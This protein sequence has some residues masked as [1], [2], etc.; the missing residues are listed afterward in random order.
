MNP[1]F[2]AF[3]EVNYFSD[4]GS[5]RSAELRC[6]ELVEGWRREHG[7]AE[8]RFARAPGRINLIGEHTDYNGC[9]AFPMA[10]DRDFIAAF[11][12]S[13]EPVVDVTDAGKPEFG[14]R[15]FRL[16]QEIEAYATGDWGNYLKA[17]AQG[18]IGHAKAS[19]GRTPALRGFKARLHGSIPPSAGLSSSSALVVLAAVLLLCVN[20]MTIPAMELASL[21]A[22]A[23]RYVGTQGG[24][25][26]QAACL[27]GR[28]G[29]ALKMD[30]FPLSVSPTVVPKGVVFVVADSLVKA[31]KTGAAM[32]RYNRRAAECRLATALIERE[33][34]SR[35]GTAVA[36]RR[37]GDLREDV[38]PFTREELR[39]FAE[40]ALRERTYSLRRIAAILD[41]SPGETAV[42]FCRRRDGSLLPEPTDGFQ[43]ARR[44][45][46][47]MSEWE[48][49]GLTQAALREGDVAE[50]G[51]LMNDS[52]ASCRDDYQISCP[53]LERLTALARD[54]GA[55]GSRLTGA[56]FGGCTVSLVPEAALD[57]FLAEVA[58]GYYGGA[59]AGLR[60]VLFPCKAVQGAGMAPP[61]G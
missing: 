6:R 10:I 3:L 4:A 26:D 2:R 54:S 30:F 57:R 35:S 40:H 29:H 21:L 43:L 38:L 13:E 59:P 11:A 25:M 27:M 8:T 44:Y 22:E 32:D 52:H 1:A 7:S 19:Q 50:V 23:E 53:E 34:R 49:V 48:R 12:A 41:T 16:E 28:A 14:R 24:G 33:L 61:L 5:P 58:R 20:D 36:V 56:G 42:R 31:E 37:F 39:E 46:H 45:R 47:V 18:I 9:S 17:A 55:L 51:R 60:D 15:V